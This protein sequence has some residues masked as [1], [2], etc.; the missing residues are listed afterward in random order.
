MNATDN[1]LFIAFHGQTARASIKSPAALLAHVPDGLSRARRL[2]GLLPRVTVSSPGG[3]ARSPD[4][5]AAVYSPNQLSVKLWRLHSMQL[6]SSFTGILYDDGTRLVHAMF[7]SYY[8]AR[9]RSFY[10][11][12]VFDQ[13]ISFP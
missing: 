2:L 6:R 9:S 5:V 3:S 10:I 8:P 11:I 1:K 12:S 7:A 4:R 13:S